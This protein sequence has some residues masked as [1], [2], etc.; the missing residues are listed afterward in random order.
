MAQPITNNALREIFQSVLLKYWEYDVAPDFTNISD[1][2]VLDLLNKEYP[3]IKKKVFGSYPWRSCIKYDVINAEEPEVN[4]D[5]RY[6]YRATVPSGFIKEYGYW[7]D[8]QRSNKLLYTN[9]VQGRTL[10]T[11]HKSLVMGYIAD[12][13]ESEMDYWLIEYLEIA[14]AAEL[15]DIGGV[16]ADQKN[17]L[18]Q[19]MQYEEALARN[20]DYEMTQKDEISP[21]VHQFQ[22]WC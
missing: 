10:K 8:A 13:Q 9:T 1:N 11:N 21:T 18:L 17:F 16:S 15:A 7:S 6:K 19:K 22:E 3:K 12:T 4:D 5:G 2:D 14:V 20:K